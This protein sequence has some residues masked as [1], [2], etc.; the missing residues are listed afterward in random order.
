MKASENILKKDY[1]DYLKEKGV[2]VIDKEKEQQECQ[3]IFEEINKKI[4]DNYWVIFLADSESSEHSKK[5]LQKIKDFYNEIKVK[6][7]IKKP[8][9]QLPVECPFPNNHQIKFCNCVKDKVEIKCD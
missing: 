4:D 7:K 3:E 2:F 1:L 9:L 5:M 8:C 6:G